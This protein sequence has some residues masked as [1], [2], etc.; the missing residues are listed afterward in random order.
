MSKA[1]MQL[2]LPRRSQ[3]APTDDA[4]VT[5]VLPEIARARLHRARTRLVRRPNDTNA[6]SMAEVSAAGNVRPG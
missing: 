1:T 5:E 4:G 6:A 3:N 2:T